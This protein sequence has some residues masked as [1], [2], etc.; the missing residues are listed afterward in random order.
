VYSHR[1][2]HLKDIY[3]RSIGVLKGIGP[4]TAEKFEAVGISTIHDL[5]FTLPT[6]YAD[7]T[8]LTP[9]ENIKPGDTVLLDA[10]I[11]RKNFFY[12]RKRSLSCRVNDGSG[13]LDL[14]FYY[15]A[16][17]H[18]KRL[19]IGDRIRCYG[20]VRAGRSGIEIVHPE[21][22]V[23][24]IESQETLNATYTPIYK[25]IKGISQSSHLKIISMGLDYLRKNNAVDLVGTIVEVQNIMNLSAAVQQVHFPDKDQSINLLSNRTHPAQQRIAL[26]E[27]IAYQLLIQKNLP[28]ENGIKISSSKEIVET[29][30]SSLPFKMT[31]GQEKSLSEILDDLSKDIPMNRLLQGD[32][33]C[34]KTLVVLLAATY[35]SKAGYQA[36][37]MA[38][39]EIL[40][41]QHYEEFV[42]ILAPL[43][44]KIQF[45]SGSLSND[46]K[47]LMM[48]GIN[49]T[50]DSIVIGTHALFQD[51]IQFNNLGLVVVDEQHR[52]GV[53]QR[54]SLRKKRNDLKLPHQLFMTATPI[55][56]TV[57][58][59]LFSDMTLS[60]IDELP[61]GRLKV[62]TSAMP[63]SKKNEIIKSIERMIQIENSQVY[64]VSP[65]ISESEHID[66]EA[67][68]DIYK[69]IKKM[70][71]RTEIGLIH[72]KMNNQE[73]DNIMQSFKSGT[74]K[75]L[76]STTL[77]EVGVNIPN[78][79]CMVI[80]GVERM[81]LS[82]IHQ[83]RGRVGRGSK[84]SFCLLLYKLPL[85]TQAQ[86][87]LAIIRDHNDGFKIAEKDFSM[88]GP[89]NIFGIEQSGVMN[90]QIVDLGVHFDLVYDA[91]KIV[92]DVL[93]RNDTIA[94]KLVM[95]WYADSKEYVLA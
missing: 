80:E 8:K 43:N 47:H 51:H 36:A 58:M 55:P 68:E 62:E 16:G 9:I 20:K 13:A 91:K 25:N 79:T 46:Q 23:I 72:G 42:K 22:E 33:G 54:L 71:P 88:R 59:T 90:F 94:D 77:I 27:L 2:E 6:R 85:S 84:P 28:Q 12:L 24:G 73:K 66:V 44:I 92:E 26:E 78:A 21:Y 86:E 61:K 87:R 19:N 81:G 17:M 37:I 1:E 32:V 38:P 82:Q 64:W 67:A 10:I 7:K 65:I 75:M 93:S 48:E 18:D 95:R 4:Q 56:R 45:L 89:G 34:G 15:Y 5:V 63:R 41:R 35:V 69:G 49:N 70:L 76:V 30:M 39:T 40:A 50:R 57:A 52:F 74:I 31:D 14:K 83:L 11:K 53:K 60:T 29:I 3:L